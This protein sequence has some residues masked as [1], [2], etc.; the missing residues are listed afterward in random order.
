MDRPSDTPETKAYRADL[1]QLLG[2]K[3]TLYKRFKDIVMTIKPTVKEWKRALEA[4][5][6]PEIDF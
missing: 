5:D 2:M 3:D 6:T 1:R 4:L